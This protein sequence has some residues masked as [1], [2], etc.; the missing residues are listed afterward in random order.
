MSEAWCAAEL[1]PSLQ[2]IPNYFHIGECMT[3]IPVTIVLKAPA[4]LAMLDAVS[5][6]RRLKPQ[7]LV[8][9]LIEEAFIQQ[10]GGK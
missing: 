5:I 6:H 1:V 7:D 4:L 3:L 9:R 8:V 10:Q 2:A